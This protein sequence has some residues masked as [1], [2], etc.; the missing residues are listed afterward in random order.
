[1]EEEIKD[2]LI[3][4]YLEGNLQGKDLKDFEN[5][6]QQDPVL[7]AE[8]E[9]YQN[10]EL[11]LHSIGADNFKSEVAQWEKAYQKSQENEEPKR[12]MFR[13]YYA[14]AASVALLMVAVVFFLINRSP[15]MD[16]LYAQNYVPY[17]DMI[18]DRSQT[19]AEGAQSFLIA[20]MEAYNHQQYALAE[21][22][23]QE[24]LQQQP[25]QYGAALYLGIAQMEINKFDA[26]EASL[27]KA[28]QDAQFAQQSQWYSA[29][30]YLKSQQLEKAKTTLQ[31]ISQNTQHYKSEEATDLLEVLD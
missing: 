21:E 17:D 2:Q 4:D 8:I 26:A 15:D 11:G 30:L 27:Q 3:Q 29:L 22:N 12:F 31:S 23:L 6:M 16:Q 5:R 1:M 14:V 13:P 28:S 7:A 18:L 9:V 10:L 20:G 25:E 24:Y 19:D